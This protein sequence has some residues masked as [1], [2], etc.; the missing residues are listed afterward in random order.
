MW[1]HASAYGVTRSRNRVGALQQKGL[2]SHQAPE[3]VDAP[4]HR[5]RQV[6]PNRFL[7]FEG[8]CLGAAA[9]VQA[10][11]EAPFFG[12]SLDGGVDMRE[13][14]MQFE[15]RCFERG[16]PIISERTTY[17]LTI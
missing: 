5:H 6:F 17:C 9:S 3:R 4:T 16:T 1:L 10:G 14:A 13:T 2:P 12:N 7:S 15:A 8:R 11:R